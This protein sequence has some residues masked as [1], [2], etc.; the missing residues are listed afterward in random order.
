M[1]RQS[2]TER[3]PVFRRPVHRGPA[4]ATRKAVD[5]H[6]QSV[7]KQRQNRECPRKRLLNTL[8]ARAPTQ[9][10]SVY[11]RPWLIKNKVVAVALY[12]SQYPWETRQA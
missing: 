5:N 11:N 6:V 7:T 12:R 9:K 8:E 10:P 3:I 2:E 1:R 4:D